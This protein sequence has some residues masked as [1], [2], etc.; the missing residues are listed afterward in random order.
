MI[1]IPRLRMAQLQTLTE[2]AIALVTPIAIVS[3]QVAVVQA[4]F[5]KFKESLQKDQAA[6]DK[7]TMDQ[8]RDRLISGFMFDVKA[9]DNYPHDDTTVL[10]AVQDVRRIAD[11]YSMG[12]N[13]LPYN[14]QSA[15]VDNMLGELA[16]V[17]A[18]S[19]P[20]I[21]R[22]LDPIRTANEDFKNASTEYV[23]DVAATAQLPSASAVAPDLLNALEG[24]FTLVVAH[25]QVSP[26]DELQEAYLQLTTLVDTYR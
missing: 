17:D 25:A 16:K 21:S 20:T 8:A 9:E 19:I 2:S 22:W 10:T 3:D 26:T 18:T 4:E 24:L 11:R 23:K 15:Q 14:E 12:V 5:D 1:S 13:R 6:S 7:K